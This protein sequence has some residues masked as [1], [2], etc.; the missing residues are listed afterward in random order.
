MLVLDLFL[1]LF[2]EVQDGDEGGV[3][4]GNEGEQ[5]YMESLVDGDVEG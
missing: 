4:G 5:P 3:G 2:D 1:F